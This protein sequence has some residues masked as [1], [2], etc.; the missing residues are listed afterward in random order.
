MMCTFLP[1]LAAAAEADSCLPAVGLLPRG[2]NLAQRMDASTRRGHV[3]GQRTAMGV[4]RGIQM[5]LPL[6]YGLNC[7][8]PSPQNSYVKAPIPSVTLIGDRTRG[9]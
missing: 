5:P 2:P 1:T 7:V 4:R 6:C 9:G 3:M 8:S